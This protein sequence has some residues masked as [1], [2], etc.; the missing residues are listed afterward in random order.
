M[1]QGLA[2]RRG[3]ETWSGGQGTWSEGLGTWSEDQETWSEDRG[4][5]SEAQEGKQLR[6]TLNGRDKALGAGPEDDQ[7]GTAADYP[8]D[9]SGLKEAGLTYVH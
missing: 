1:G 9:R 3:R 5:W 6:V 8:G 7:R 4:T 2:E